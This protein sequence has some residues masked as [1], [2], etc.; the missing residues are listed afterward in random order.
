MTQPGWTGN[1]T[2]A[3]IWRQLWDA[4]SGRAELVSCVFLDC[5][6]L[7][8]DCW[9]S[10]GFIRPRAFYSCGV[11]LICTVAAAGRIQCVLNADLLRLL[12]GFPRNR[13]YLLA[14]ECDCHSWSRIRTWAEETDGLQ[15]VW[16]YCI[17]W[18]CRGSRVLLN[19]GWVRVVAMG[20]LDNGYCTLHTCRRGCHH[21]TDTIAWVGQF[22]GCLC[23]GWCSWVNYR[24]IGVSAGELCLESSHSG[25]MDQSV[26]IRPLHRRNSL[27]WHF[28]FR[29]VGGQLI[30]VGSLRG[31]VGRSR[32]S[33]RLCRV[34]RGKLQRLAILLHPISGA[35]QGSE[36]TRRQW[37]IQPCRCEWTLYRA[38]RWIYS[39]LSRWQCGDDVCVACLPHRNHSANDGSRS[40]GRR[41]LYLWSSCHGE[42]ESQNPL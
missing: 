37:P 19:A 36:P 12:W 25:W 18:L 27:P 30:P 2:F 17:F 42:C 22:R 28:R 32:I 34:W 6:H 41:P 20:I 1:H 13:T 3:H 7:H 15:Y 4:R 21:S 31:H 33:A 9:T 35:I 38:Y 16:R 40:T 39:Q 24:S 8:F 5:G 10:W 23:A 26:Y 14:A 11:P 29:R